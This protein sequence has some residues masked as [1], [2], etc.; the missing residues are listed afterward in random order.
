M[1]AEWA[2]AASICLP[3][4]AISTVYSSSA[5]IT[6]SSRNHNLPHASLVPTI[7]A[8]PQARPWQPK[9]SPHLLFPLALSVSH[10]C[11]IGLVYT[12]TPGSARTLVLPTITTPSSTITAVIITQQIDCCNQEL[13]LCHQPSCHLEVLVHAR[14]QASDAVP[15]AQQHREQQ[16]KAQLR[17]VPPAVGYRWLCWLSWLFRVGWAVGWFN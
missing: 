1:T 4:A 3:P 17:N 8:P 6:Y 7:S 11:I 15:V 14:P 13:Q 10:A 12:A 16:L 5:A 2:V 9:L